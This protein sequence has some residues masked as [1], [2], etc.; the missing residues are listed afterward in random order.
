MYTVGIDFGTLSARALLVDVRE[1]AT[2]VF[3]YTHG[4]INERLPGSER[5]LPPDWE[6][7]DPL[8]YIAAVKATVPAVLAESGIDP[9]EVIGLG[10]DFTACTMLPVKV[11]G[12]PLQTIEE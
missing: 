4:V 2:P 11:D 9:G 10:I 3:D 8:D 12:T 5:D 7:Q 1:V 6:L